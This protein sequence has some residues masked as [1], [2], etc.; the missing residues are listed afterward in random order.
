[1]PSC[2]VH[3][4]FEAMQSSIGCLFLDLFKLKKVVLLF[5]SHPLHAWVHAIRHMGVPISV[6][7]Y[8]IFVL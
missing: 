6:L 5:F 1:M 2:V 3:F 8:I 4:L 7:C